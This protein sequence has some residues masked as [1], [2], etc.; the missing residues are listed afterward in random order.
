MVRWG[1]YCGMAGG[2]LRGVTT[3]LP[4]QAANAM[5]ETIYA[6]TDLAMLF[7]LIAAG[8]ATARALGRTG[9]A[10]W[11]VALAGLA[12]IVGPDPVMFGI[13]FYTLG[14]GIFVLA[15]GAMAVV[16]IARRTLRPAAGLWVASAALALASV[17]SPL[18]FAAA[19]LVLGL[20]FVAAGW[21]M[22]RHPGLA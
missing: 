15:L 5:L 6:A 11:A 1:A 18:A 13:D 20:G 16:L 7:A 22:L 12:S 2:A 21:A 10:C 4:W 19:G 3:F 8:L 14:A 17:A 9:F